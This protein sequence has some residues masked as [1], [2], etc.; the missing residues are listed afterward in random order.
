[1]SWDRCLLLTLAASHPGGVL[2]APC[3]WRQVSEIP[4]GCAPDK[5]SSNEVG[6]RL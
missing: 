4:G 3:R 2:D 6:E 1:M 5:V